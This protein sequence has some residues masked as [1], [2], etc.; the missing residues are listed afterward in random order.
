M[1]KVEKLNGEGG[2]SEGMY[3]HRFSGTP[4]TMYEFRLGDPGQ[5][6]D[7]EDPRDHRGDT[8]VMEVRCELAKVVSDQTNDGDRDIIVWKVLDSKPGKRV[9][10]G[11]K[12]DPNQTTIDGEDPNNAP[13]SDIRG[14]GFGSGDTP[15]TGESREFNPQSVFSDADAPP[16]GDD[17]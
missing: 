3:F 2:T 5:P 16:A 1:A 4:T 14:H 8:F 6:L 13:G 9:A 12:H 11:Q 7:A 10:R 15:A 17:G